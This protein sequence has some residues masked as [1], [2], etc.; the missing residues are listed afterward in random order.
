[1]VNM[2]SQCCSDLLYDI[3]LS[4]ATY[5]HGTPICT[6]DDNDLINLTTK[7]QITNKLYVHSVLTPKG[8]NI[9]THHNF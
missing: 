3:G 5:V 1:M 4:N 8:C 9:Y 7:F 2:M 6:L